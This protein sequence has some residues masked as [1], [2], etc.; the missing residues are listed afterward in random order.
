MKFHCGLK[1]TKC[2]K[3]L[4]FRTCSCLANPRSLF[5]IFHHYY[6]PQSA[7]LSWT[8]SIWQ[9]SAEIII[10][11][12]STDTKLTYQVQFA[13]EWHHLPRCQCWNP[14]PIQKI[15]LFFSMFWYNSF[16]AICRGRQDK[17]SSK[18]KMYSRLW[19]YTLN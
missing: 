9:L 15:L 6:N 19:K 11:L 7:W 12:T 16:I 4:Y 17:D 5:F 2:N 3:V 14:P 13:L 18:T 1:Q 10:C 8:F